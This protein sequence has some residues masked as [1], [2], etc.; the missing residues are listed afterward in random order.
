MGP[1]TEIVALSQQRSA[2]RQEIRKRF[3]FPSLKCNVALQT[4]MICV[5]IIAYVGIK[6]FVDPDLRSFR[7]E[8]T[9]ARLLG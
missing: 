5:P 8:E 7:R 6:S 1:R 2:L 9:G 4:K 3:T